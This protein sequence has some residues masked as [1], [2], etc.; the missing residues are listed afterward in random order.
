MISKMQ[1]M[2]NGEI[3]IGVGDSI[4]KLYLIPYLKRYH[5]EYPNINIH[6]INAKSY[7]IINMLKPS[8]VQFAGEHNSKH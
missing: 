1:K 7:E 2:E 4:C 3:S 5:T 8:A 6:I